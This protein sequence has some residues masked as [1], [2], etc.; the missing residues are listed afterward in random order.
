MS[1]KDFTKTLTQ[2]QKAALLAALTEDESVDEGT[3]SESEVTPEP[4]TTSNKTD[5]TEDFRV[6]RKNNLQKNPR[7]QPV[8]GGQNTWTDT[9]EHKEIK[10]PE[11]SRT[12]RN[13]SAPKKKTITCHVCGK[14][15]KVNASIIYGE[16][17]RCSQCVG[18]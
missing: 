3:V 7:R 1:M 4:K 5:I 2:E 8:Q 6:V 16:Y 13:R 9:G 18:R 14:D 10:T 11:S 15:F 12:P 17:Y